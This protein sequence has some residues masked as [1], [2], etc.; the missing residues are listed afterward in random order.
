MKDLLFE[1]QILV[2]NIFCSLLN[3]RRV[4][5][6]AFFAVCVVMSIKAQS[7][8]IEVSGIRSDKGN[9]ML[10]AQ[11]KNSVSGD[12]K[13]QIKPVYKMVKAT[14]G[15]AVIEFKDFSMKEFDLSVFHDENNNYQLDM[16]EQHKPIEGFIRR[17]C[18]LEKDSAEVIKMKLYY[19][20]T[21]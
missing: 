18:R 3:I 20:V 15:I 4:V 12:T 16:D 19:P 7:V 13:E 1:N 9:I 8:K 6:L 17:H 21:E 10:M 2:K 14:K 5:I 11:G